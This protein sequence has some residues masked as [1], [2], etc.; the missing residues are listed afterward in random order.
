MK[1]MVSMVLALVLATLVTVCANAVFGALSNQ[2]LVMVWA[3]SFVLVL[4]GW[5][6]WRRRL[7]P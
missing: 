2:A 7:D 4:V 1:S 5:V 3:M 6:R